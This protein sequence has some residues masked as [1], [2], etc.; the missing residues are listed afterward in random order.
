MMVAS[1][2]GAT[3]YCECSALTGEGVREVFQ[4]AARVNFTQPE[5]HREPRLTAASRG[6]KS[7]K[8]FFTPTPKPKVSAQPGTVTEGI[9]FTATQ[10]ELAKSITNSSAP[11]RLKIFRLLIIGKTGCGKT[12]I[13]SKVRYTVYV[14]GRDTESLAG[15]RRERCESQDAPIHL[16]L[17]SSLQVGCS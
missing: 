3:H 14:L 11:N 15:L 9:P 13:L 12:T 1:E 16:M 4:Y 10:A 7:I 5:R 8:R 17:S 2:I 6:I